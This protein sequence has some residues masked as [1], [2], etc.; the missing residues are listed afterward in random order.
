MVG[1]AV[2]T[3]VWSKV[4]RNIPII[5]APRITR[6]LRCSAGEISSSSMAAGAG[7]VISVTMTDLA[8]VLGG[9]GEELQESGEFPAVGRRPIGQHVLQPCPAGIEQALDGRAS[10][11]GEQQARGPAVGG[12]GRADD[13]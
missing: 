5:N 12:I 7:D 6:I 8:I 11:V 4:A 3:M 9:G 1:R 10:F 13:E 2:E